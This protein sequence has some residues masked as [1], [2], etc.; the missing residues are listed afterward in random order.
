MAIDILV[1]G[2]C[3]Y[4]QEKVQISVKGKNILEM[5]VE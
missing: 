5:T 1:C 4:E 3:I 2:L